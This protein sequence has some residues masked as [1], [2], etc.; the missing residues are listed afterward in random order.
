MQESIQ[1]NTSR[2]Y[3]QSFTK[4]WPDKQLWWDFHE[5]Q[6]SL[7]PRAL[8]EMDCIIRAQ[9]AERPPEDAR[10][11]RTA[12]Q[13]LD[14]LD[15]VITAP[16]FESTQRGEEFRELAEA[17]KLRDVKL[18]DL[19]DG[20][21]KDSMRLLSHFARH[22]TVDPYV[23]GVDYMTS[24]EEFEAIHRGE[25]P[26]TRAERLGS[27]RT[28]QTGRDLATFVHNDNPMV[29]W[30]PVVDELLKLKVPKRTEFSPHHPDSNADGDFTCWGAPKFIGMLGEVVE[31]V[32][33][34]SFRQKWW[35]LTARP[36]EYA[37]KMGLRLL[38]QVFPEGS[39]MH[40]SFTAMH[41]FLAYAQAYL[42]LELFDNYF[43]LPS[44][45]T[46][47]YEVELWAANISD[48]RIWAGVHF[49]S[50]NDLLKDRARYLAKRIAA[51]HLQI[52]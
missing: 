8:F 28:F 30:M 22:Q 3:E 32:G 11:S 27:L 19:R 23:E 31:R 40:C 24:V 33:H 25:N 49:A 9:G 21:V 17:A 1:S 15:R 47:R 18:N 50:D 5:A 10:V 20:D 51:K 2:E 39:P 29:N 44:G 41:A 42:L 36:E 13:D 12:S 7:D 37:Y 14:L 48:A 38:P 4:G 45:N 43:I 34:L 6:W 46:V 16:A 52:S 35:S 26:L